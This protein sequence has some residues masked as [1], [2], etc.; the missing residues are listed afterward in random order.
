M[1]Q[2]ELL[3]VHAV[4]RMQGPPSAFLLPFPSP[5]S[6]PYPSR[7][8]PHPLLLMHPPPYRRPPVECGPF[9]DR[10]PA[11]P[12]M[13]RCTAYFLPPPDP[14]TGQR[15]DLLPL[16]APLSS[17]HEYPPPHTTGPRP[18]CLSPPS[19]IHSPLPPDRRPGRVQSLDRCP[20]V[21]TLD[22][23]PS[24]TLSDP[25]RRHS[26][27]SRLHRPGACPTHQPC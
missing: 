15:P 4:M 12:L 19:I 11:V 14:A 6:P 21:E 13:P 23:F 18:A 10:V 20:S 3:A 27:H 5:Q 8:P 16:F 9:V 1:I 26:L 2:I 17:H 22:S 7:P 25:L 24:L